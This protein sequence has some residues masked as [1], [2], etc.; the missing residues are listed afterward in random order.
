[1]ILE[2]EGAQR[3]GDSLDRIRL[4]VS[5]VVRR[6]DAPVRAGARVFGMKDAVEHGIPHVDVSRS[7]ID[8]GA[9]YA[10]TV[11]EFARAHAGKQIQA[12]VDGAIAVG[13]VGARFR[14]RSPVFADFARREIVD[15]GVAVADQV[16]APLVQAFEVVRRE[17]EMFAPVESQPADV[18]LNAVDVFVLFLGGVGVVESHMAAAAEAP[19]HAEIQADGLGVADMEI[20]VGLRRKPGHDSLNAP[21]GQIASHDISDEV[22]W[23]LVK[24]GFRDVHGL[25][26]R[27]AVARARH[28]VGSQAVCAKFRD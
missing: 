14:Q 26:L 1:M 22:A 24:I 19:P 8:P 23:S 4:P 11:G 5:E 20:S 21:C 9:K 12:L 2:L 7:H 6:V 27:I 18:F 15:V 3:M 13:T 16:P 25:G 28:N 17:I 10:R